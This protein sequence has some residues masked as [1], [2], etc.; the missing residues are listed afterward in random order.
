MNLTLTKEEEGLSQMEESIANLSVSSVDSGD[1]DDPQAATEYV[2]DIFGYFREVE[3]KRAPKPDYMTRQQDV[4]AKM[5]EILIDW[6]VEVHFKFKL[7]PETLFLTVN[8]IDRFLERKLVSRSRLQLVGCTCMLI[9]AKYEEIFSPEV[10]D[11]VY[12]SDKAYTKEQIIHMEGVILSALQFNLTTPTAWR[13]AQRYGKVARAD[14]RTQLL[15]NYLCESTLQDY[16]LLRFLPSQIAAASVWLANRMV[17]Q[18]QPWSP[19]LERHTGYT[20]PQLRPVIQGIY[21]ILAKETP[22]YH[23]VRKKFCMPKYSEVGRMRPPQGSLF[24]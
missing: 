21:T 9:A 16:S 8:I 5:R 11:F 10:K 15:I 17:G 18:A 23:A 24:V 12:I 19:S 4:N 7:K 2:N 13:F 22:Q 14:G 6:L 1:K 3:K 20:E